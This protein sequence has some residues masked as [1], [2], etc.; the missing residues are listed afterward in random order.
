MRFLT[1]YIGLPKTAE[2][3]GAGPSDHHTPPS[4]TELSEPQKKIRSTTLKLKQVYKDKTDTLD[5]ASNHLEALSKAV[6]RRRTPAKL[7]DRAG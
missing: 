2:P 5:R 3:Y 7:K 4:T 1:Q 6:E